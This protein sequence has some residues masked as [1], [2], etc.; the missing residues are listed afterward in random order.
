M[1]RNNAVMEPPHAKYFK[2]IE[3]AKASLPLDEAALEAFA[4]RFFDDYRAV[5]VALREGRA[6]LDADDHSGVPDAVLTDLIVFE[7]RPEDAW[8]IVVELV[9]R[10]PDDEALGYVGAAALEDLIQQHGDAFADRIIARAV[11]DGRWRIALRSVWGWQVVSEPFRKRA[12]AVLEVP[13]GI[14]LR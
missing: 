3:N 2:A 6:L 13:A 11:S 5:S 1:G 12:Y 8:P 10:A 7:G 14:E 4:A 9:D